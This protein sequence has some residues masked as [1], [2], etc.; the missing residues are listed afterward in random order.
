MAVHLMLLF[1]FAILFSI[2]ICFEYFIFILCACMFME[3]GVMCTI[4]IWVSLETRKIHQMPWNWN[5]R[6]LWITWH[7]LQHKLQSSEK[8]VCSFN[9]FPLPDFLIS[10]LNS[11]VSYIYYVHYSNHWEDLCY[12]FFYIKLESTLKCSIYCLLVEPTF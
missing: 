7:V 9:H 10:S 6:L 12:H 5:F 3:L 11:F 4:Y 2:L 8:V 1:S